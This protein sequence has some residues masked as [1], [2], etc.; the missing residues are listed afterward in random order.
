MEKALLGCSCV[1]VYFRAMRTVIIALALIT[2][3]AGCKKATFEKRIVNTWKMNQYF[4]SGVDSTAEFHTLFKD[5]ELQFYG[6]MDFRE[7]YL[8]FGSIPITVNGTWVVSDGGADV[9]LTDPNQTRKYII[10]RLKK[11]DLQ[12]STSNERFLLVPK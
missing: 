10:D 2:A 11:N 8:G 1:H 3:V 6:N 4:K 12:V 9:T 7:F 5:Y